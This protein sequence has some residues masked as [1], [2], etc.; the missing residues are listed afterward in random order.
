M[1][2]AITDIETTGGNARHEKITEIAIYKFDGTKIID[3]LNTLVNPERLIPQ[4]IQQ[5]TGITN[6]MVEDAPKFYEIAR[7]IVELTADCVFVAHNAAFDYNFIQR[8]FK[9]LGYDYQR[10]YL[11]TVKL[12]RKLFPGLPSYSLGN[13]TTQLNISI[14]NRHRASGDAL[15]TVELFRQLMI[16]HNGGDITDVEIADV[17][18]NINENLDKSTLKALPEKAGVYYFLNENHEPIYIGKSINIK[19][20]VYSHFSNKKSV[21][22]VEMKSGTAH[23]DYTLTGSELVA[24]LFEASEVKKHKPHYNRLLR[25]TIFNWGLFHSTDSKGYINLALQRNTQKKGTALILFKNKKDGEKYI[26]NLVEKYELC[27]KLC[28]LYN[29]T[30]ACFHHQIGMCKGACLGIEPPESYN[31]RVKQVVEVTS[32]PNSSFFIIDKGRDNHEKAVV[33][34]ENGVYKGYGFAEKDLVKSISD[35]NEIIDVQEDNKDVRSIIK[36]FLNQKKYEEL[37]YFE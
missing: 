29:S 21:R 13:L 19:K 1:Y 35:L 17:I 26:H 30:S 16:Q 5:L 33:K 4:Y 11:C 27:Q 28:G 12:S 32:I 8:E 15:A 7:D 6:E 36:S 9:S 37:I 20:R 25:R 3:Q 34:I 10:Q 23:I 18:K 14:E 2:Y 22:A 24:L 31:A